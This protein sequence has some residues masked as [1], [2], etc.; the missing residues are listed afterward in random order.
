MS[1]NKEE[2]LHKLLKNLL[3]ERISRLEKRNIEQT[4]DLKLCKDSFKNQTSYLEKLSSLKQE[5]INKKNMH[6]S[7]TSK[8]LRDKSPMPRAKR[9]SLIKLDDKIDKPKKMSKTPVTILRKVVP[10]KTLKK[11]L[12]KTKTPIRTDKKHDVSPSYMHPTNANL[13]KN[14]NIKKRNKSLEQQ[15]KKKNNTQNIKNKNK[16]NNFI[17]T[18]TSSTPYNTTEDNMELNDF[19]LSGQLLF[20]KSVDTIKNEKE[21]ITKVIESIEPINIKDENLTSNLALISEQKSVNITG[22]MA[23]IISNETAMNKIISYLDDKSKYEFLS[24]SKYLLKYL[25]SDL[26]NILEVFREK[27]NITSSST[28]QDQINA[29]KLKYSNEELHSNPPEF[30]LSRGTTKAIE[31]LNEDTYNKIFTDKENNPHLDEIV[32]V[33]RIFCQLIKDNDLNKYKNN[34][35]FWEEC[36]Q[37]IMKNN[38]GKTGDFFKNSVKNFDFSSENIFKIK[39]IINGNEEMLKPMIF[40]KICGTTG[41]VIFLIKDTLEYLGVI[42]NLKKNIPCYL[43]KNLEFLS[44]YED[45]IKNYIKMIKDIIPSIVN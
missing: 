18:E 29:I 26:K 3:E 25:Y 4:K 34:K 38:D 1:I 13:N 20:D 16:K 31:L 24:S 10:P 40:S 27:N 6:K 8:L 41:L 22:I 33:Y 17:K 42:H 14:K 37:Y 23:P 43:L 32:V 2:Q 15:N 5:N 35:E 9:N 12:K 19:S 44:D 39:K 28:I 36:S 45:K 7:F 11:E 21:N 30:I